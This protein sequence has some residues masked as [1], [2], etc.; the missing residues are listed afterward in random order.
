MRQQALTIEKIITMLSILQSAADSVTGHGG[1]AVAVVF[2]FL[3]ATSRG[4]VCRLDSD[5]VT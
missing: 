2:S 4:L 3:A 1:S 5:H